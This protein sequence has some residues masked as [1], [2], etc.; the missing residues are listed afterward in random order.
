MCRYT[1]DAGIGT[2]PEEEQGG[3]CHNDAPANG[4][5][6]VF[7]AMIRDSATSKDEMMIVNGDISYATARCLHYNFVNNIWSGAG[8]G[9]GRDTST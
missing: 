9:Y 3:A 5:D 4:A 1:A 6:S 7:A 2:P 8:R